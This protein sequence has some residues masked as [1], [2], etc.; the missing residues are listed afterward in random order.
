M[1]ERLAAGD[2]YAFYRICDGRDGNVVGDH[3][4]WRALVGE[5]QCWCIF[6]FY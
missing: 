6:L 3:L 2:A 4:F 1:V 5:R